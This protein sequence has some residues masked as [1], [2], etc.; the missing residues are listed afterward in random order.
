MSYGSWPPLFVFAQAPGWVAVLLNATG[1][2]VA[3]L[4]AGSAPR[5]VYAA[6][7][8]AITYAVICGSNLALLLASESSADPMLR[9]PNFVITIGLENVP[10]CGVWLFGAY[11]FGLKPGHLFNL[12]KTEARLRER[13]TPAAR[14][15]GDGDG[16]GA[17]PTGRHCQPKWMIYLI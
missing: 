1:L 12:E 5:A 13:R 6:V 3:Q 2:T 17:T 9:V 4:R 7:G 8:C 11:N 14:T 15:D 16:D 10:M